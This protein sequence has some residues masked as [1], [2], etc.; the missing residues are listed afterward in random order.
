MTQYWTKIHMKFD[1]ANEA[2]LPQRPAILTGTDLY[3]CFCAV[4]F[5]D[6]K[7]GYEEMIDISSWPLFPL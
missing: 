2:A 7:K 1:S 4:I 6:T 5:P 3:P